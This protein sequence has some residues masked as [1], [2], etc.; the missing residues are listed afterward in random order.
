MTFQS[1]FSRNINKILS[2]QKKDT[3]PY[4]HL[5]AND[6]QEQAQLDVRNSLIV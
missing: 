2:G 3:A 4:D 1:Q 6:E 5:I